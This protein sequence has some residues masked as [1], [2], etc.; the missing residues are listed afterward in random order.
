MSMLARYK[1]SG[2][3]IELV[4]LIEES[5]EPKRSQ[6]LKMVADE[7]VNFAAQVS[8]KL[9]T[10]ERIKTLP[11]GVL[12]EIILAT[13]PKFIAIAL[14]GETDDFIMIVEKCLGKGFGDYKT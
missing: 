6:L 10:Y 14:T 7:D 2:G 11:E 1:K 8:A 5:P 13:P 12:A 9:F 3:L 4:K